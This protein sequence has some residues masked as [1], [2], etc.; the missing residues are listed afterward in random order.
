M[1]LARRCSKKVSLPADRTWVCEHLPIL[2]TKL[3]MNMPT[4]WNT[5][6]VHLFVFHTTAILEA[7]GPYCECNMLDVE[8]FHTLFKS[9][10][11]GT[12]V[13]ASIKN[14]YE[15]LEASQ[16]N[17]MT[18]DMEWTTTPR[19]STPAG[20]AARADSAD[21]R[22]RCVETKG[23]FTKGVL[24]SADLLQVQDLWAIENAGYDRFRDNF[25]SYNRRRTDANKIAHIAD[26]KE[27]RQRTF[28]A[29]ERIWQTMSPDVKVLTEHATFDFL[30]SYELPCVV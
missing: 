22:D 8:R 10:A 29:E 4:I 11:R 5:F 13:M 23:A 2:M 27:T 9:F 26:W 16:Q 20:L 18:E 17:R 30:L 3:E 15:I 14:N 28:S 24:S 19:R 6:V 21:K 1:L 7:A 12:N 25:R